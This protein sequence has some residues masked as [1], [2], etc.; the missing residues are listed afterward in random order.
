MTVRKHQRDYCPPIDSSLFYAI[1]SDYDISNVVSLK[2]LQAVL[3]VLKESAALEETT[4]FDPSGSSGLRDSGESHSSPERAASWHG[5]VT[6]SPEQVEDSDVIGISQ[7]LDVANLQSR[8]LNSVD[9]DVNYER[10]STE[11]K[12][13]ELIMM[14]PT[15]K[16]Y[17]ITYTLQKAGHSFNRA[18]EELLNVAFLQQEGEQT[19]E[20]LF[21][22]GAEGYSEPTVKKKGQKRNPK[23]TQLQRRASS[24]PT[25]LVDRANNFSSSR[26]RWDS[27]KEDVDFIATRTHIAPGTIRSL[28]HKNGA[29]LPATIAAICAVNNANNPYLSN[30]SLSTLGSQATDLAVEFPRLRWSQSS[31]LVRLTYP[32]TASARELAR[33]LTSSRDPSLEREILPKYLPPSFSPAETMPSSSTRATQ[34]CT[35][36]TS[37]ALAETRSTAFSQASSAYRLS[38]SK[39]LMGGAAA[40]YSSVGR[41]ASIAMHECEA[42]EAAALVA[43][44][45]KAGE[46]DLHGV[47]VR[48]AV[49]IVREKVEEWWEREGRE[50]AREGK[51]RDDGLRVITG[52]GRHSEGRKGRLGPAVGAMLV[53]EGWKVKIS[54][55]VIDVM[56]RARR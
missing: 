18:L 3:E 51:V 50:W 30:A 9:W 14:F 6:S 8:E 49:D 10:L 21:Y 19:G 23:K 31:A 17:D 7:A 42:T 16:E 43:G 27:A 1:V 35:A 44:Q 13:H 22:K 55:G 28:Y 34:S 40:Y 47:T 5:Y 24:T 52:K 32:S 46:V 36:Y 38:K 41:D 37:A 39:P 29:S 48:Y 2:K 12:A 25:P 4:Q 54:P 33:A 53:K 26:S 15:A 20:K 11:E 45:S 56:G